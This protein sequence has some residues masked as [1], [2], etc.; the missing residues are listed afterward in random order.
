MRAPVWFTLLAAGP[1]LSA[2]FHFLT[3]ADISHGPINQCVR[4]LMFDY[5]SCSNPVPTYC[6]PA[7]E[8]EISNFCAANFAAHQQSVAIRPRAP[9]VIPVITVTVT[10]TI[11]VTAFESGSVI[12]LLLCGNQPHNHLEKF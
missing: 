7:L 4:P 3:D 10:S 1:M 2:A 12:F 5:I 6:L 9:D 11:D 8:A